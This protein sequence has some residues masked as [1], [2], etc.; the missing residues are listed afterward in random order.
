MITKE[1]LYKIKSF[2]DDSMH[3]TDIR[4]DNNYTI[5]YTIKNIC[6]YPLCER[7][8]NCNMIIRVLLLSRDKIKIELALNLL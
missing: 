2:I 8:L 6:N 5:R 7:D 4:I 1:L 3:I